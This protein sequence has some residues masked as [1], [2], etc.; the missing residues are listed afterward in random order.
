M[1]MNN[2]GMEPKCQVYIHTIT[3]SPRPFAASAVKNSAGILIDCSPIE[4]Y[5]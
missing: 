4:S 2:A 3:N 1:I 5:S